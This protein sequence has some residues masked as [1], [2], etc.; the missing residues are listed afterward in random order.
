MLSFTQKGVINANIF[1]VV[2]NTASES[3]S[4]N[5]LNIQNHVIQCNGNKITFKK[6]F[7]E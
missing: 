3:V 4:V 1:N 6:I 2:R 5:T 7:L